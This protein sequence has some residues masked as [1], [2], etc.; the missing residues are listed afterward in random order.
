MQRIGV[1]AVPAVAD[2]EWDGQALLQ[3]RA[4]GVATASN[5]QVNADGWRLARLQIQRAD[6]ILSLGS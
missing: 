6:R 2:T 5:S 1:H 4:L 3:A